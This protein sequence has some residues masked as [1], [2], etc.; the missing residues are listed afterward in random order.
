MLLSGTILVVYKANV[1]SNKI[2]DAGKVDEAG[3]AN[4]AGRMEE[5]ERERGWEREGG[6]IPRRGRRG[7]MQVY[8][9]AF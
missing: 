9:S 6:S 5:E 4:A 3:M 1:G 8:E 2:G 7:G